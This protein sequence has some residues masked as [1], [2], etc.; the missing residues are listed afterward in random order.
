MYPVLERLSPYQLLCKSE[1]GIAANTVES[2]GT[3]EQWQKLLHEQEKAGDLSSLCDKALCPVQRLANDFGDY[4][5]AGEDARFLCFISLK[6]FYGKGNDYLAYCLSKADTAD[7]LEV[8]IYTAILDIDHEDAKL[9]LWIHQRRRMLAS[10]E[11]N[12]ALMKN[13]CESATIKGK[14]ILWYI[15]D[16]TDEERAALI[17]ALVVI[18][19]RMMS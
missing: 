9:S 16:A 19:I 5:S 2:N 1:P 11:E 7:E 3:P 6:V 4:L 12:N 13:F 14:D 8:G 15:S 17:H 18:P 10:L